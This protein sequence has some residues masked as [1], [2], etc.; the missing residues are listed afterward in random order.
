[1]NEYLLVFRR[2]HKLSEIQ[3]ALEKMQEHLTGWQVF[4]TSIK[5]KLATPIRLFDPSG[6]IVTKDK[7]FTNGP[8]VEI[9][10][11]IGGFVVITATDYNEAVAIAQRCP[12][13]E[14][15]G[16]VEVRQGV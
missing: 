6:R 11:S 12:V 7:S 9:T 2:D 3:P 8:F 4:F 13:L 14:I 16:T 15:G 5:E 10:Q 1:M